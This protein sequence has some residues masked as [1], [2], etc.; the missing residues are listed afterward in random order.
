MEM[1]TCKKC[2][3]NTTEKN[4]DSLKTYQVKDMGIS[5]NKQPRKIWNVKDKNYNEKKN[6]QM[7]SLS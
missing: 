5:F 7:L 4:I 6:M 2:L 1:I 3:V